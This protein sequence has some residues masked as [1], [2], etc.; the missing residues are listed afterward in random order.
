ML[1]TVNGCSSVG[2]EEQDQN[3]EKQGIITITKSQ[4]AEEQMQLGEIQQQLFEEVVKTNG[5]L[6]S[7]PSGKAIVNTHISGIIK[8]IH[9]NLG[10]YVKKGQVLCSIEGTEVIQ[11]QQAYKEGL[12]NLNALTAEYERLKILSKE[13]IASKKEFIK[14]ESEYLMAQ[15]N[16]EGLKSN[17][18]LLKLDATKIEEGQISSAIQIKAPIS[19]F[20]SIQNCSLG[21]SVDPQNSLMQIVDLSKLHLQFIVFEKD[22]Q[23][24]A[25][26]QKLRFYS[27][28][29]PKH[30]FEASLSQIGKYIN[31]ETKTIDCL[32]QINKDDTPQFVSNMF[33]MVEIVYNSFEA[34]SLPEEALIQSENQ[35]YV[36]SLDKEDENNYY[37]HKV[38][39]K[40]GMT[41][42]G[43]CQIEI[44]GVYK[45]IITKGVYNLVI[46]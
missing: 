10:E 38:E 41:Q 28:E 15:A 34:K 20:I 31:P 46:D 24:L 8:S 42:N 33:S 39:V 26:N 11:V 21:Q 37:F 44:S 27:P 14:A 29:E 1:L 25:K 2:I 35:Y 5:R 3:E 18:D 30:V 17:L 7:P 32:A 23:K 40:P 45:K 43:L 12:A 22:V 6:V 19:G 9:I 36:L 4:F 16:F 13:N